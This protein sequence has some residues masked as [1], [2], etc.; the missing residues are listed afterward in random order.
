M[1]MNFMS[2][3]DDNCKNLFTQGQCDRMNT[4]LSTQ[5]SSLL[6][7]IGCDLP[8][9]INTIEEKAF[10]VFPNPTKSGIQIMFN[11]KSTAV[12][13]ITLQDALGRII[14]T[15]RIHGEPAYVFTTD[16]LAPGIYILEF[17]G[18]GIRLNK[19]VI[20]E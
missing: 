13:I 8:N 17:S 16:N 4:A 19:K 2:F 9:A 20:V 14:E 12:E 6:S 5:R 3:A 1:F 10:D 18:N 11:A 15:M 7:S